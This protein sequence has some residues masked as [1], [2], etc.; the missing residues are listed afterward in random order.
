LASS[1]CSQGDS[2]PASWPARRSRGKNGLRAA[3][4]AS[5][6]VTISVCICTSPLS[7]TTQ[8]AVRSIDTSR[9]E[10]NS[11]AQ[12]LRCCFT[13]ATLAAGAR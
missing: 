4:I 8:I 3:A 7:S 5:G 6:S 11:I 12:L 13:A 2:E 9:P 1:G 10:K